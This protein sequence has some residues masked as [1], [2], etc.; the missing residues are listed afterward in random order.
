MTFRP[1]ELSSSLTSSK[2]SKCVEVLGIP[3]LKRKKQ[4][5]F[6]VTYKDLNEFISKFCRDAERWRGCKDNS[7]SEGCSAKLL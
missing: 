7:C 5:T 4:V 6:W 1:I 2:K 3:V